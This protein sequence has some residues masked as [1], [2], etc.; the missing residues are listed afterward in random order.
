MEVGEMS[1][2]L[3]DKVAIITGS[4][5]GIG[6]SS[7]VVFAQEG[8]QVVIVGR[9]EEEGE[10]TLAMVKHNG[11]D[12]L[13]VQADVTREEDV[14][15]MVAHTL[16]RYGKVDILFNNAGINPHEGRTSLAQCPEEAWD[17]II[18]VN[19]KGIYRCSRK[20]IPL[21]IENGGGVI[22]NTSSTYGF[23]GFKDRAAYVASKGAVSQ[24]TKAMAIDY[25]PHN[26]RVNCICPGM[27]LNDRV[28]AFVERASKEGTL[29]AILADYPLGR[30]GTTEEIAR[31]AAFLASD[32]A[33]WITGAAIPVDGGYTAR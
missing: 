24:L 13:Y 26:I 11:G 17:V 14:D 1:P 19:I 12:A 25:G 6:R 16:S 18:D 5:S 22:I 4:T 15:R 23:V 28:Q 27:V 30:L 2:R 20:V 10:K 29:E 33:S 3:K 32:D 7:A 31:V 9:R 8:A 21:M